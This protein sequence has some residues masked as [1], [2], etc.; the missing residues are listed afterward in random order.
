MASSP[1]T[2]RSFLL[3]IHLWLGIVGSNFLVV[4]GLTGSIMAFANDIDHWII[5]LEISKR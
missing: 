2:I 4:L 3:K 5:R 1:I